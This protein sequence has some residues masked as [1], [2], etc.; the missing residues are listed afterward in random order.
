MS[1]VEHEAVARLRA[2]DWTDHDFRRYLTTH[3]T[4]LCRRV[5]SETGA[6]VG[7]RMGDDER[8]RAGLVAVT[9]VLDVDDEEAAAEPVIELV[10]LIDRAIRV[11]RRLA[12][13]PGSSFSALTLALPSDLR[14][15]YGFAV[16]RNGQQER[17]DD[18]FNPSRGGRD[19]RL[20]GS[21]AVLP[22]ARPLPWLEGN[23][24]LPGRE[25]CQPTPRCDGAERVP[26]S[27][28]QGAGGVAV[29]TPDTCTGDPDAFM[30]R[31][32]LLGNERR[33]WV[34]LPR[35]GTTPEL[36]APARGRTPFVVVFDGAPGHA[37]VHVRDALVAAGEVRP[38]AVVLVDQVGLRDR[39]LTGN[40]RFSEAIARELIPR[41]REEYGLSADPADAVVSGSSFGGLCAGFTARRHPD[42]FGAAIMQ[43]P[44]CWYVPDPA[45]TGAASPSGLDAAF[46]SDLETAPT[47]LLIDEFLHGDTAPIRL[48]HECGRYEY[49]PP[50]AKVWQVLG[51]RWLRTVLTAR[52]YDTVYRE[53]AGGHDAA[54]WRGTWA[55]GL[56]W[57]LGP[58]A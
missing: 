13:V 2:G 10:S 40:P 35:G 7:P 36:P 9:F 12:R 51:N 48:F 29:G 42:V 17:K 57:A 56:V 54:W 27:A 6:V 32:A 18:P 28:P 14:F 46:P 37:A 22:D 39:E 3:G 26:V 19:A 44:S 45:D 53:F 4:P 43:S 34:S 38:C 25:N 1:T 50:P 49:G 5:G 47:P 30:F 11:P 52:G 21:V 55:D 20:S 41:L 16:M 23:D 31:S 58:A 24:H 15:T 8:L 33:V